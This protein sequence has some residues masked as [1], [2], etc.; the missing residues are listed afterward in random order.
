[1]A[2]AK[3][4]LFLWFSLSLSLFFPF[5]FFNPNDRK[6]QI[7]TNPIP[8]NVLKFNLKHV[9]AW[10]QRQSS[11]SNTIS[12]RLIRT[13][14]AYTPIYVVRI[15]LR[16][17]YREDVKEREGEKRTWWMEIG[18]MGW[19]MNPVSSA[20]SVNTNS[21]GTSLFTLLLFCHLLLVVN[22]DWDWPNLWST[23]ISLACF[24][25][26]YLFIHFLLYLNRYGIWDGIRG[27]HIILK[28]VLRI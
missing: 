15:T 27:I 2:E 25:F 5:F 17:K 9:F 11:T 28:T 3:Q 1:M 13:Y 24:F 19:T 26:F 23:A 12:I 20:T 22:G 14:S 18:D 21:L 6:A 10:V 4:I 7:P 8:Q 16:L